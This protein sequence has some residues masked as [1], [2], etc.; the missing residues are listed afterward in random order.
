MSSNL[1]VDRILPSTG[2]EVGVGTATGSVAL[3]GDV[4]IAGTL[5]YEDVTN[6]DSVGLITARNGLQVTG[7]NVGINEASPDSKFHVNSGAETVPAR[8]ESTGTQSRI[9]FKAS[10]TPS[11]YHVACGAEANNFVVY[12]NNTEKLRIDSV[13]RLLIGRTTN[14]ASSAE[15]LTIDNGMAL[16]RRTHA[17]AAAVYIRNE[18]ST[19]DTRHPYLIFM[20]GG[21]NR[22]G[23]GIQNDQSSLWISGQNGIAFRTS[24]SAPSQEERLRITENGLIG[25]GTVAPTG[26]LEV[27]GN[28][29]INISNATRTGTNGVQWRLIPHNGGG[30]A[31]NLRLYEDTTAT[32]VINITKN[33]FVNIG[34]DFTQTS[35]KVMINGGAGVGQLEVKGTEAD[36]WMNSSGVSGG[37][38]WRV[39]GATGNTIHRWRVYDSTNSRDCINVY[40]DGSVVTPAQPR[41]LAR[42]TANTTYN[43]SNFGNYID[44]DVEDYDI[45]G[46]FT[47]SGTDQGLF[48]APV[49]GMYIFQGAAYA[50]GILFTQSWFTVNGSRKSA[51]DWVPNQSGNFIQNSQILNLNAGDKVGFHPHK[52]GTASFTIVH[53]LN[54]TYFKGCL[55]G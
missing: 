19:A 3:Y 51:S 28:D 38:V 32:E 27:H 22:G 45:G 6:I 49:A 9:G 50:P 26:N 36:I 4:N 21:G 43:P 42:L 40:D 24:G 34:G 10:G 29:G 44:F 7:G 31:T 20:D 54:H 5:T 18:D 33:G 1:R 55:L 8:F 46:N 14:L 11:S 15:R 35:R 52:G 23:F 16:F 37:S 13:G 39:M 17:S 2:T 12:T 25:I 53:N 41:F 30:S 47:T 48:T